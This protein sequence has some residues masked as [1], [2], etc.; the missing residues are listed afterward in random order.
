MKRPSTLTNFRQQPLIGSD[1]SYSQTR[2]YTYH[3]STSAK[4][5]VF[6]A[7]NQQM[8]TLISLIVRDD[9]LECPLLL[10]RATSEPM[11]VLRRGPSSVI[12]TE[13]KARSHHQEGRI[14][15][16]ANRP[17]AVC[18]LA[19]SA[20]N[21]LT[22]FRSLLPHHYP[23]RTLCFRVALSKHAHNCQAN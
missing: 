17:T 13:P 4:L 14:R 15:T 19:T 18:L 8:P 22:T 6:K 20:I 7:V 3:I 5:C 2:P 11:F 21:I 23:L 10:S 1:I 9:V 12:N 16:T